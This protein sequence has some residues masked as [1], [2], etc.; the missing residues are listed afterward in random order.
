MALK[1]KPQSK[2]TPSTKDSDGRECIIHFSSTVEE[3][4][5]PAAEDTFNK[6][7]YVAQMRLTFS[8]VTHRLPEISGNI[9]ESFDPMVHGYH[10]RCYQLFTLLPKAGKRKISLTVADDQVPSTSKRGRPSF[11][12]SSA[13]RSALF[14]SDKQYIQVNRKKQILVRCV[15]PT[16]EE[17]IKTAAETKGDEKIYLRNKKTQQTLRVIVTVQYDASF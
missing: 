17:S 4:I 13:T 16:A 15:T 1:T 14:P 2:K 6:I 12:A 11:T 7:K 3:T 5:T 10:R 8:D 9:P